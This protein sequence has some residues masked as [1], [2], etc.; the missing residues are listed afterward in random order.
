M[1]ELELI[2]Q[3]KKADP[4]AQH[5]LFT[6]YKRIWFTICLRYAN[7]YDDACDMLQNALITIY[8]KLNLF[9][10][11][12]GDFKAWSNRVVINEAIMFLRTLK[13]LDL[14]DDISSAQVLA[15]HAETAVEKL[16]AEE[17]TMLL[18][19]LPPGYRVVFNMYVL[20]G[21][22]HKEI[23]EKLG[24]TEGTSKS[25]YFKAKDL[26]RRQLELIL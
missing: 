24:V 1:T 6:A 8:S 23:A 11:E 26:L 4:K 10:A 15:D 25:Q 2:E 14:T 17:L 12:L 13:Y 20:E 16:S 5:A 18:Q 3:C 7:N 19:K 9:N 22:T 21:Y